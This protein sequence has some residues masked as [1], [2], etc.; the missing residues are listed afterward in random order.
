MEQLNGKEDVQRQYSLWTKARFFI[1]SLFGIFMFFV[2]VKIGE[3]STIPIDHI[4]TFVKT[5]AA[6]IL[7][8][9]AL[10]VIILGAI[11]PF[12]KKTWNST[13]VSIFFSVAKVAG[14]GVALMAIFKLGPAWLFEP[15]MLPFLFDKLVMPVGILVP[16]GSA[17]LAFM[18][19]YGLLEFIGII[20]QPIMRPLFM[21]PG[22][23]A[24]D[25]VASFV[26][27]YSIALLI[28]NKVFK[29]GQYTIK[30]AAI[31]ATGFSTVSTTFMIIVA[32]TLGLMDRWNFYFW[33]TMLV[34]FV[35]TAITA[36]IYPLNRM[37]DEYVGNG[38]PEKTIKGNLLK[39][40]IMNGFEGSHHA[41][42]V[43]KNVYENLRDGFRMTMGILPT[44]LSIGLLGLVL[45]K[46]TPLFDVMGYAFL[47][48]TMLAGIPDAVLAAKGCAVELAEMFLP[49]LLTTEAAPLTRYVMG[50][51]S[52]SSIMFFSASIPCILSTEIPLKIK[53]LIVI[54]YERTV[55][56]VLLA[57]AIGHLFL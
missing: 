28:T 57:A 19:G 38:N 56:S 31:I 14:V 9:Y 18:V 21:T 8:Y 43:W 37:K 45:A 53:D 30:E 40:A 52:I 49:A 55:I 13:P 23:S 2:T 44:I 7:P 12:Y 47:P 11:F 51:I 46:F 6:G 50:V 17:F 48:W 1:F 27:S 41:L 25:A 54:W 4:V 39:H 26:G 20:M 22:K 42:P 29:D 5:G 16:I 36:R 15:D 24:V 34:T 3:K 10:A 33:T 32:K 35:V